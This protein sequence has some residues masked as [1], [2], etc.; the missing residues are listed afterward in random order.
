MA[1]FLSCLPLARTSLVMRKKHIRLIQ[2]MRRSTKSLTRTPQKVIK[3]KEN[4]RNC[5]SIKK[6]K[7]T[8]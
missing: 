4:P 7:G 2:R 1:L 3:N 8:W 5:H 6:L